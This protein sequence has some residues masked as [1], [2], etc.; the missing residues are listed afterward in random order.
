MTSKLPVD[1][2]LSAIFEVVAEPLLLIDIASQRILKANPAAASLYGRGETELEG[3]RLAT[4][5]HQPEKLE[6]SIQAHSDRIP[7]SYHI[8]QKGKHL[9]VEISLRYFEQAHQTWCLAAIHDLSAQQASERARKAAERRYKSIYGAAPYPILLVNA[10]HEIVDANAAAMELYGL[11]K[12]DHTALPRLTDLLVDRSLITEYLQPGTSRLPPHSH[13]R[14]DCSE[15]LAEVSVGST[16]IG[17][18]SQWI[19]VI[20]DVT[21]EHAM[22][23]EL[24]T[25]EER[26]RFA[27]EGPGSGIWEW[28][29]DT[30]ELFVSQRFCDMLKLDERPENN[31]GWWDRRIHP[32]DTHRI[33]TAILS[34]LMNESPLIEAEVRV[35]GHG[36]QYH[37]VEVRAMAM[38]RDPY[39][40]TQRVIG[41][42][43]IVDE[44]HAQQERERNQAA[45]LLHMDR[46]A[47]MGEMATL[48]AHELNQPLAAIGNFAAT[49]LHQ[50][51]KQPDEARR[52]LELT[53]FL[54]QRAG[55]IVRQVRGFAQKKVV[56]FG[57]LALNPAVN[58]ILQFM[59]YQAK[60][61]A[62]RVKLDLANGLPLLRADGT[63]IGQLLLNLIKNAIEATREVPQPRIITLRTRQPSPTVIELQVE[64]NGIGL[65][66]PLIKELF[67]PFFTTKTSGLGMGLSICRTIVENHGGQLR[68]ERLPSG[69]TCFTV[70]LP[71][72]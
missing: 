47:S 69:I 44:K 49:A 55:D 4:L 70:T 52:A 29:P 21:Q 59:E 62:I 64:D 3:A 36:E 41:T 1:S 17:R 56:Q 65:P 19:V 16:R 40:R 5:A 43:R 7:L 31:F 38:N 67:Q 37:W 33:N 68:A 25:S 8:N 71:I 53:Q 9:P 58:E 32:E 11:N 63:Q 50:L 35:R 26:W 20:R 30:D 57:D 48:I 72:S 22:L 23:A 66:D 54:V 13:R 27:L 61:H 14:A 28:N 46:L 39:G 18:G 6:A 15:F 45:Q 2:T 42:L 34:H 10:Q 60:A 24:H 51:D 12:V